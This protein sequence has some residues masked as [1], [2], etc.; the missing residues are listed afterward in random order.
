[1][2]QVSP[3]N[4]VAASHVPVL[5]IHGLKDKNLPPRHSEIIVARSSSRKPAVI[6]WEPA[7]AMHTGAAAAEPEEYERRVIGWFESHDAA[8]LSPESD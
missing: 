3:E 8:G 5:L 2:E 6:L 4:A 1:M 7:R